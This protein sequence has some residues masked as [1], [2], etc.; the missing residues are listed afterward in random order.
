MQALSSIECMFYSSY[1][2]DS[3]VTQP[4]QSVVIVWNVKQTSACFHEGGLLVLTGNA[5]LSNTKLD[6]VVHTAMQT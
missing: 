2:R 5:F 4:A 3:E 6:N 1:A